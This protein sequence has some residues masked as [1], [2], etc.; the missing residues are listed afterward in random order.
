MKYKAVIFDLDGTLIHTAPEYRYKIIGD[1]LRELGVFIYSMEHIDRVWFETERDEIIIKYFKLEPAI[2]WQT[3]TKNEN[4]ELRKQFIKAYED[5]DFLDYA[6][7]IGCRTGVVTGSPKHI[8]D[9][10]I[11]TIGK[12]KF[13]SVVVARYDSGIRSKPH[14]HGLE[15]CLK[16]LDAKKHEVIFIGNAEEDIF[17]ARNAGILD[18]FIK[19]GE[20]E[21]DLDVIKPSI[22]INSLYEL[23]NLPGF[24]NM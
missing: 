10:E 5:I 19:R 11:G 15:E 3:Y 21:F 16:H 9:L 1:T 24:E 23:K 6:R 12:E 2:F 14:P 7:N 13:D 8:V 17:A 22:I 18:V 20:H 4:I